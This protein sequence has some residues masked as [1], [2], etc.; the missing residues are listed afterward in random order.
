VGVQ[1]LVRRGAWDAVSL[2]AAPGY[3]PLWT[4]SR[5]ALLLFLATAS[6]AAAAE[7]TGKV[8]RGQQQGLGG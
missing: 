1:V 2:W 7:L 4:I 5:A 3:V 6:Y 8:A